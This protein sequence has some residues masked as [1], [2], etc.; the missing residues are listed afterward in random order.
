MMSQDAAAVA[1]TGGS[2]VLASE[3]T[4]SLIVASSGASNPR[5]QLAS[6]SGSDVRNFTAGTPT[7]NLDVDITNRGF[8]AKP[9]WGII[10]IYDT[11]FLG[12]YD[13]D[14]GSTATNARFVIFSRD[15][16]N[17]ATGNR[18]FHFTLGKY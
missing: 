2:T 13:Y 9:D 1:I 12:V 16:G 17:L 6:Y 4:E 7:E 11:N 14:T 8:T 15:G 5:A 10:Q 3:R 18:R